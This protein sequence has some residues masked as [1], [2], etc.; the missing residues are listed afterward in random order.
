MQ[1]MLEKLKEYFANTPREQIEADWS[2]SEKYDQ[3]GIPVDEFISRGKEV[4]P[5]FKHTV[6]T[7]TTEEVMSDRSEMYKFIDFD[8]QPHKSDNKNNEAC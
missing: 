3:V 6:R 7:L 4:K 5:K 1:D 2:K 8:N